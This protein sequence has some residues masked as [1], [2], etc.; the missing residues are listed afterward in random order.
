VQVGNV[1]RVD[2]VICL[3]L[4]QSRHKPLI[5]NPTVPDGP[6]QAT[7]HAPRSKNLRRSER[8]VVY[9]MLK[10]SAGYVR[11]RVLA[12]VRHKRVTRRSIP[13]EHLGTR[14]ASSDLHE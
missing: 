7:L 13:F 14:Q 9:Q 5:K 1:T 6:L 8:R 4:W 12:D 2:K 11:L 3:M 10:A